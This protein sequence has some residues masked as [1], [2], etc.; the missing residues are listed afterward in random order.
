M[1]Q[2]F[3]P[4]ILTFCICGSSIVH[5]IWKNMR[6]MHWYWLNMWLSLLAGHQSGASAS[7]TQEFTALVTHLRGVRDNLSRAPCNRGFPFFTR[8]I[9][10]VCLSIWSENFAI[11]WTFVTLVIVQYSGNTKLSS[12]HNFCHQQGWS[13]EEIKPITSRNNTD[14]V[15][16]Q[17]RL[18]HMLPVHLTQGQRHIG[19]YTGMR[20]VLLLNTQHTALFQNFCESV[21][22]KLDRIL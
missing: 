2:C 9:F 22:Q 8:C 16:V 13:F 20:F 17:P 10:S 5:F 19:L 18:M 3:A 15:E 11:V 14:W 7:M 21:E 1:E 4:V 12:R 6:F